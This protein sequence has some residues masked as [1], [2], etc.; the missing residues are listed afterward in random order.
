MA[1][2]SEGEGGAGGFWR[3]RSLRFWLLLCALMSVLPMAVSA[4][5]GYL[6][7]QR[8]IVH[9]MT[10]VARIDHDVLSPMQDLPLRMWE[11]TMSLSNY[12][13]DGDE[14]QAAI[15]R[16]RVGVIETQ[17]D[18]LL[19]AA[20]EAGMVQSIK[21]IEVARGEWQDATAIGTAL[22]AI[23]GGAAAPDPAAT[24]QQMQEF[25]RTVAR[26]VRLLDSIH[27]ELENEHAAAYLKMRAVVRVADTIAATSLCVALGLMLLSV[28]LMERSLVA[29]IDQLVQGAVRVAAGDRR[30]RVRVEL[31]PELRKVASA[32]NAMTDQIAEQESLLAQM[33]H[34]DGL[35]GL[36]NRREFD[37]VLADNIERVRR[38]GG[39]V[40]LLLSDIDRFKSFND[41]FGHLGGD[42]ALRAVAEALRSH[43][44]AVDRVFRFGGEEIAIVLPACDGEGMRQMAERLRAGVAGLSIVLADGRTSGVTISLG[45][46][47]LPGDSETQ[48]DLIGAADRALY[49]SKANGRDRVTLAGQPG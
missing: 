25:E 37:R 14:R 41:T 12:R 33:A 16:N 34:T 4:A 13:I 10:E 32:F 17:F 48:D 40:G 3:R 35:T 11:A 27:Q 8:E 43:V 19:A 49:L 7:F 18:L 1:A 39:Q 6:L 22:T 15:Y 9:P 31:P 46:A 28:V 26:G 5:A 29:G 44:R 36:G 2:L 30:H 45:G 42:T 21:L 23:P 47:L 20:G 38:Y 24:G